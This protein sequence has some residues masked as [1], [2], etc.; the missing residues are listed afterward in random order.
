MSP[1][2][3]ASETCR[4]EI[5][6]AA[7][8]SKRVIPIV[9]HPLAEASVPD[10]VLDLNYIYFCAHPAVPSAGFG[11]GLAVLVDALNTD[12]VWV[13]ENTRLSELAI[14]WDTRGRP[15]YRLL[16][17]SDVAEA[18]AWMQSQ[19]GTAPDPSPVL[20]AFIGASEEAKAARELRERMRLDEIAHAQAE[21]EQALAQAEASQAVRARVQ[22]FLSWAL[23]SVAA[24]IIGML[25]IVI[26]QGIQND[27]REARVFASLAEK[28]ISE[29]QYERAMRYALAAYPAPGSPP[30]TPLSPELEA[31]LGGAALMSRYRLT[32]RGHTDLVLDAAF[33]PDGKSLATGSQDAT[34]RL[35]DAGSGAIRQRFVGHQGPIR[36]VRWSDDGTRIV[37]GSDDG[38]ARLWDTNS[39][40]QI[41]EL[42]HDGPVYAAEFSPGGKRLVTAADDATARVWDGVTGA[43]IGIL[44]G[45]E[46]SVRAAVFSPDGARIV[47]ASWDNTARLWNVETGAELAV[48]RGHTNSLTSVVFSPDGSRLATSS[49]DGTARLW[50][51][52]TG[53]PLTILRGHTDAVLGAAFSADGTRLLTKSAD[54]SARL[55]DVASGSQVEALIGHVEAVTSATLT[56][57]NAVAI[58]TS[59]DLTARIW[60]L[61]NAREVAIL[62][63]HSKAILG[64]VL[65]P[66]S[67][68]FA[69]V[70]E[71]GTARIW[72]LRAAELASLLGH[73][74]AVARAAF[75]PDGKTIATVSWD[76]TARLWDAATATPKRI[77]DGVASPMQSVSFDPLGNLIRSRLKRW[78]GT[79]LADSCKLSRCQL[80]RSYR[81]R[82]RCRIQPRRKACGH[83]I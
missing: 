81:G 71:D 80:D 2:A 31:K 60:D 41:A 27:T 23:S 52:V 65:A 63:G 55:W 61:K 19:P 13:H 25:I 54:R 79:P 39:G 44:R 34:V 77:Y 4:W 70:S 21:R 24:L 11:T 22:T 32:L 43:A 8:L 59:S 66:D 30:W 57:D 3:V 53:S 26:H 58:T 49:F 50:D 16:T 46:N 69:T 67:S 68:R 7:S 9:A 78:S 45:H 6:E 48:L 33:S 75:S 42:K 20:R 35:W 51:A 82:R 74:G 83:S 5:N 38:T 64:L 40:K 14:G 62:R 72:S 18:K 47:T 37:T 17:G 1:E 73:Q 29:Q 10:A 28:A 36:S 12:L 15:E 56:P 76:N